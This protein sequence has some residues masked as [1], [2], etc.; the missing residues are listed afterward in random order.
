MTR[1]TSTSI[2]LRDQILYY[3]TVCRFRGAHEI[4]FTR[5]RLTGIRGIS[6]A[7]L[8]ELH[9]HSGLISNNSNTKTKSTIQC[10]H[11]KLTP[12]ITTDAQS[13]RRLGVRGTTEHVTTISG[14]AVDKPERFPT[15][16]A[17]L[18]EEPTTSFLIQ[19]SQ[20]GV[21]LSCDQL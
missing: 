7:K 21:V 17:H 8:Q 10:K 19:Q 11:S 18:H 1:T 16:K 12:A 6:C 15:F 3:E 5:T 2:V 14:T 9:S 13:A 20:N 4:V